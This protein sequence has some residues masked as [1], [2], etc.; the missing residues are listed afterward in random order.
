MTPA[1]AVAWGAFGLGAILAWPRVAAP[2]GVDAPFDRFSAG[3]ALAVDR[4]LATVP[5]PTGSAAHDEVVDELHTRLTALGF[6]VTEEAS[7]LRNLVARAPGAD[8]GGLWL[9]AHSDSVA[10]GPGAADDGLGLSVILEAARVLTRERVPPTLHVLL[11]D[12]EEVD[13]LGARAFVAAHPGPRRVLNLEAR[14]T[15]GAAFMFQVAGGALTPFVASGC[16]AQSTSLAR[17]V[18]QLL[19]NDTDFTVFRA[20]GASGWDFALIDG[21]ERYHTASDTVDALAP[22]S[23][24]ALGE[25][26]VALAR[27][28]LDDVPASERAWFQVAGRTWTVPTGLVRALGFVPLLTVRRVRW[29]GVAAFGGAL[30]AAAALGFVGELGLVRTAAFHAGVAEMPGARPLYVAAD[31]AAVALGVVAARGPRRPG[32]S[33][34][35]LVVSAALAIAWPEVGYATV[36]GAWAAA[37][38][39]R[40][41]R[42][43]PAA[44]FAMGVVLGPLLLAL[45]VALTTRLLPALGVAPLFLLAPLF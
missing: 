7:P 27:Q 14:G 8:D 5:R 36:P 18:Y 26:V 28:P 4:T 12:G 38:N 40:A 9:V 37:A 45:P 32:F 13:L 15:E 16:S 39:L 23:V 24:Q 30:F 17:A 43:L 34:A 33:A 29:T 6:V 20:A 2:L 35:A 25:C 42:G 31:V 19:P 44:A 41:H 21:A 3:R 11:T 22:A 10:A 1:R